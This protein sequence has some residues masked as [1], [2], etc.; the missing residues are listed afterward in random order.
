M[1]A[2]FR[3]FLLYAKGIGQFVYIKQNKNSK[4]NKNGDHLRFPPWCSYLCLIQYQINDKKDSQKEWK[5]NR[6]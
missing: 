4:D 6:K 1:L 3:Y 5:N 2:L